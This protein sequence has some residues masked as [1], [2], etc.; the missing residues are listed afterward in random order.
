MKRMKFCV[1]G[2][3]K[4]SKTDQWIEVTD[5]STGKIMAEV[6]CCT[7]DEVDE[8][9]ASADAAFP[10][11]SMLSLSKRTQMMFHWRNVLLEHVDE[12]TV[13]CAKEL[14]KTLNEA[15]GDI[16]KAIEDKLNG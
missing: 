11:W 14:G 3:W 16:L 13:L 10:A 6:P 2:Q 8:A 7:V 4:D 12:L 5:S 15:K 9:I 1:N